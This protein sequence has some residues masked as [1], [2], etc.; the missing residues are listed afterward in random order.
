MPVTFAA[1]LPHGSE[2]IPELAVAHPERFRRVRAGLREAGDVFREHPAEL[3]VVAT[4]HGIRAEGAIALS[5]AERTVG[6]LEAGDVRLVGEYAV[7]APWARLLAQRTAARRL[8]AVLL[9]YGAASGPGSALPLDWGAQVPLHFLLGP[10]DPARRVVTA[11]P[12]RWLSFQQLM[13]FGEVLGAML[14]ED[15]RPSAFVA[16][17]DL[18]HAHRAD[19]PYGFHEAAAILDGR[20]QAAVAADELERLLEPDAEL[21]ALVRHGKPDGLWQMAILAGLRRVVALSPRYL[22]YDCP[23][24]FGMLSAVYL[25][26]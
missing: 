5:A 25:P 9:A 12:S 22:G 8:P 19:G 11:V 6:V 14:A 4:P 13:D 21:A 26:T 3:V 24:Y 23:T 10:R 18:C 2:A 16:S 7:D 20:I 17:A 1:I 15:P